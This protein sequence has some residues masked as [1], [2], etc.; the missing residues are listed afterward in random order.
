MKNRK[1]EAALILGLAAV[2]AVAAAVLTCVLLLPKLRMGNRLKEILKENYT[3]NADISMEGINFGLLGDSLE[4]EITGSHSDDVIYGDVSYKGFEY[5]EVY[6]S[7]DGKVMLNVGKLFESAVN[8]AEEKTGLPLD[9]VKSRLTDLTI[10]S[11]QI[12]DIT[13]VKLVTMADAGV[14]QN[15]LQEFI[16]AV[17]LLSAVKQ[18]KAD[19]MEAAY[20]LLGDDAMYFVLKL[21]DDMTKVYIGVPKDKS[22]KSTAFVVE[23]TD[24]EAA[25]GAETIVWKIKLDYEVGDV[26]EIEIPDETLSKDTI[27]ILKKVYGYLQ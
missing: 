12:E 11:D 13:G 10:S 14:T 4:G 27:E 2:I 3:Y 26:G 24:D 20:K 1:K 21:N 9:F 7:A 6:V 19:E 16:Q 18:V 22:D 17:K 25:D 23:Y 15:S 8:R 5:L